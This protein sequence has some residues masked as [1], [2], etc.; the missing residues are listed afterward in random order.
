MQK[1]NTKQRDSFIN[2]QETVETFKETKKVLVCDIWTVK[3]TS[4]RKF[5]KK[6]EEHY[7][8]TGYAH[9]YDEISSRV[10]GIFGTALRDLD[11]IFDNTYT[12]EYEAVFVKPKAVKLNSLKDKEH[13]TTLEYEDHSPNVKI[14]STDPHLEIPLSYDDKG[15]R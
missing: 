2:L 14:T 12:I 7:A 6:L 1:E 15:G 11:V 10:M 8:S 4:A 5:Y 9:T 13:N 3:N